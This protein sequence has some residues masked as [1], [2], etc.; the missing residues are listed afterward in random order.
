MP[1]LSGN[2]QVWQAWEQ[3]DQFCRQYA[4]EH[5]DDEPELDE[6]IKLYGEH[7]RLTAPE[8]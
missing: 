8:R 4:L 7:C 5:P 3:Y 6:M 1:D 2:D